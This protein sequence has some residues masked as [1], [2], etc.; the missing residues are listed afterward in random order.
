MLAIVGHMVTASGARLSGDIAFNLPYS[1]MKAGLGAFETIPAWGIAQIIM[2]I[3][4]LEFGFEFQ[5]KSI[6]SFC[7]Q[8]MDGYGWDEATQKKKMA[9]ELNNGR[10]AQM[11]ILGLIVHEKLDGNPYVLNSLLGAPVP[12]NQ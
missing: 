12:F 9:I 7:K 4:V 8:A 10:A 1:S 5:E 3:G 6:A 2:F 11:G